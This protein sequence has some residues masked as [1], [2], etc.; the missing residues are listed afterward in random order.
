MKSAARLNA[1]CLRVWILPSASCGEIGRDSVIADVFWCRN[2]G[3]W[4]WYPLPR[5]HTEKDRL[6]ILT[7][8]MRELMPS[9]WGLIDD[10][11]RTPL[12][13]TM[14]RR[15]MVQ[16]KEREAAILKHPCQSPLMSVVTLYVQAL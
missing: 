4:R 10:C 13:A 1:G 3:H 5:L 2:T 12:W 6:K 14:I 15:A 8:G 7:T 9:E 11:M 16:V